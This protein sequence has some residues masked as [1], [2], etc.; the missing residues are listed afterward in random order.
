MPAFTAHTTDDICTSNVFCNMSNCRKLSWS[1]RLFITKSRSK[2]GLNLNHKA[3]T[4]LPASGV[5]RI[6]AQFVLLFI[7]RHIQKGRRQGTTLSTPKN[8]LQ[9]AA[10]VKVRN[11]SNKIVNLK[12]AETT[13][14]NQKLRG[15]E[16]IVR[17]I[18]LFF[19]EEGCAKTMEE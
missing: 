3:V 19:G 14:I 15:S 7:E 18:S 9:L 16:G 11:V 2:S 8:T 4:N 1:D 12:V 6:S 17:T 10:E 5:A 13:K